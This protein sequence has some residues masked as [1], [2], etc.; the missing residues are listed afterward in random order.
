MVEQ[1]HT[2]EQLHEE[3]SRFQQMAKRNQTTIAGHEWNY[4]TGGEGSEWVLLI[5]GGGGNCETMFRY[6]VNLAADFK[7]IAPTIPG[8]IQSMKEIADGL[9]ALFDQEKINKAHVFGP[10]LGGM[11]AQVLAKEYPERVA[12]SV[13]SHTSLPQADTAATMRKARIPLK[14][15]PY[16]LF[17]RQILGSIKKTLPTDIPDISQEEADFWLAQ[18]ED[19]VKNKLSKVD[20]LGSV[21]VQIDFNGETDL[22]SSAVRHEADRVMLIFHENDTG[23]GKEV[24]DEMRAFYPKAEFHRLPKYG[25]LGALARADDII[26]LLKQFFVTK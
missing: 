5:H 10:S 11:I 18:F 17:R 25:H 6:F 1:L 3:K 4:V 19:V 24:Q 13:F 8:T 9:I 12:K 15:M 20:V 22:S 23:F 26:D 2:V 16:W 21:Y 7:I 14:L